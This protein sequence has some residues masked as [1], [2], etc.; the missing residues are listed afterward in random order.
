MGRNPAAGETINIKALKVV[1]FRVAK[2]DNDVFLG[3]KESHPLCSLIFKTITN[4]M[5]FPFLRR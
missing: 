3:V 5:S 1:K 4:R 2:A